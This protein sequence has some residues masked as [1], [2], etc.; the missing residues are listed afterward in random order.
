MATESPG[1]LRRFQRQRKAPPERCQQRPKKGRLQE[2]LGEISSLILA[3][4]APL[5]TNRVL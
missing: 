2:A 3:I 1:R 5:R 4:L